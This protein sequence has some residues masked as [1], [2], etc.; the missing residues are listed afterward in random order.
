MI[1]KVLSKDMKTVRI[2]DELHQELNKIGLRGE[3]F[4]VIIWKCL[5]AYKKVHKVND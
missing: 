1:T 4:E 2:S 5:G 3:S